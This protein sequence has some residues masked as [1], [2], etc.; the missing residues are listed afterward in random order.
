MIGCRKSKKMCDVKEQHTYSAAIETLLVCE[1]WIVDLNVYLV[2]QFY[3]N[4]QSITFV[5]ITDNVYYT[6]AQ[7]RIFL[8][9]FPFIV[10]MNL[11]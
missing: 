6:R 11:K 3:G 8:L 10:I 2:K 9:H 4:K 5:S 1:H 7:I